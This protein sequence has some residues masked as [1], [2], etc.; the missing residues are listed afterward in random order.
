VALAWRHVYPGN[1]RD[2]AFSLSTDGGRT[3]GGPV[4]VSEDKW[5]LEGCPDD[6][7]SMA[8]SASGAVHIAW[9]TLVSEGAGPPTI[10][11]FYAVSP[12]GTRFGARTRIPTEGVPHHPQLVLASD[13]QPRNV[14]DEV[15]NGQRRIAFA[16]VTV[17]ADGQPSFE[18]QLLSGAEPSTYPMV[19]STPDGAIAVWTAGPP[20]SSV[21]RVAR[22]S[23]D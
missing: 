9:P 23:H 3:F 21:I 1:L 6:G 2:I 17:G 19:A 8:M 20:A 5:Q 11:L 18:R 10:G 15:I 12:D 7:P 13:G 16:R 14:W 22:V 4:R